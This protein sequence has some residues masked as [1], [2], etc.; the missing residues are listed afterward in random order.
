MD[1]ILDELMRL[2]CIEVYTQDSINESPEIAVPLA[3]ETLVL[4][5]FGNYGANIK[6]IEVL[7]TQCTQL[8]TGWISSVS[9]PELSPMLQHYKCA[10]EIVDPE[11]EE[12][13]RVPLL[14]RRQKLIG[15]SRDEVGVFSP[16]AFLH[17]A[18]EQSTDEPDE[19]TL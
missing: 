5:K 11:P 14:R 1:S 8:L 18:E 6:S 16:L 13:Q 17:S 10:W 12:M 9:E 19:E 3:R 4:D 7:A 2:E 15:K